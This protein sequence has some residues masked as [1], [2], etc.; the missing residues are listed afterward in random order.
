MDKRYTVSDAAREL[1]VHE[2]V[3]VSP[4]VL[5]DLYYRRVL[6]DVYCPIVGGR[7]LI[8]ADYLPVLARV[9]RSRGLLP[10]EQA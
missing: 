9:L 4:K 7:R 6:D 10:D 3:V 1:T 2:G 5:T 8:P